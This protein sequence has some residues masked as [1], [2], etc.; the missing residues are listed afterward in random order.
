MTIKE[1]EQLENIKRADAHQYERLDVE[2]DLEMFNQSS[3][4]VEIKGNI[5]PKVQAP[6][7]RFFARGIDFCMYRLL[8]ILVLSF[9]M[10]IN[11][12]GE[13]A[14]QGI[15][16]VVAALMVGNAVASAI[17]ARLVS[18]VLMLFIEPLLL[19][20][21]ATTL[22]KYIFGIKVLRE[23]GKRLTYRE[24]FIRTRKVIWH[25]EGAYIVPFSWYRNYKS[26]FSC[27]EGDE[28]LWEEN[29]YITMK[30]EH[31]VRWLGAVLAYALFAAIAVVAVFWSI[32]PP[33]KGDITAVEFVENYNQAILVENYNHN[34]Q[35][36]NTP[37]SYLLDIDTM[38][39]NESGAWCI[40]HLDEEGNILTFE[41]TEE[42]GVLMDVTL[43]QEFI[44]SQLVVADHEEE[45]TLASVA[46][47]NAQK[48]N[49][50][51][52]QT[53]RELYYLIYKN[54]YQNFTCKIFGT[55]VECVVT[56]DGYTISERF[57][58]IVEEIILEKESEFHFRFSI[59]K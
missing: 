7:R 55:S 54:T 5:L 25:G 31:A 18:L 35:Y 43:K 2:H 14:N 28:L 40:E 47:I 58:T 13:A 33:N 52:M 19:S 41:L 15:L 22:G 4:L 27:K 17:P 29:N 59:T 24:A 37:E 6:W 48:S 39:Q 56:Y 36:E 42:N 32:L 49:I 23:D 1:I 30:D 46:Y 38:T 34:I 26:Y 10:G 51:D 3:G 20:N 11:V 16:A 45:M 9:G 21:C 44:D 57:G 12:V 50:F 53:M 8:F